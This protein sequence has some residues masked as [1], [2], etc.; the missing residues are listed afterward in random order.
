[1]NCISFRLTGKIRME[2][3]TR[4]LLDVM[5][6]EFKVTL[7]DIPGEQMYAV[8]GSMQNSIF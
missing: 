3:S 4:F 1:M 2:F 7:S 6:I 8:D 5:Y